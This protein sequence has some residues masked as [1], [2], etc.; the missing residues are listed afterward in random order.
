MPTPDVETPAILN[1]FL[2][3]ILKI[4]IIPIEWK[5]GVVIKIP[6]KG[7]LTDCG[8]RRGITLSL[9]SLKIFRKILL[10][11]MEEIIDQILRKRQTGFKKGRRC[12]LHIFAA[13]LTVEYHKG[14]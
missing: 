14:Y 1:K 4:E 11:H 10:N 3:V 7:Q 12:L 6:A 8:N 9:I 2:D 5:Q 13:K